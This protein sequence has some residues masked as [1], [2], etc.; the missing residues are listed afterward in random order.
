MDTFRK[1]LPG[2]E[3]IFEFPDPSEKINFH[4]KTKP[5][6]PKIQFISDEI[7]SLDSNDIVRKMVS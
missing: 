6:G 3:S 7:N 5:S 1:S 2:Y 4:L